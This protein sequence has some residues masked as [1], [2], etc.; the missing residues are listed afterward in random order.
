MTNT[1]QKKIEDK[2][3]YLEGSN[4][5][6]LGLLNPEVV[7]LNENSRKALSSILDIKIIVDDSIAD[8][9]DIRVYGIF[10]D[11]ANP[12]NTLVIKDYTTGTTN[13]VI[14]KRTNGVNSGIVRLTGSSTNGNIEANA[15]IDLDKIP[16]GFYWYQDNTTKSAKFSFTKKSN[17]SATLDNLATEKVTLQN[18]DESLNLRIKAIEEQAKQY[19]LKS[20]GVAEAQNGYY[21]RYTG[22]FTANNNYISRKFPVTNGEVYYAGSRVSG[23]AVALAVYFNGSTFLGYQ[24]AGNNSGGYIQK[25]RERLI[26]PLGTTHIG[27][28]SNGSSTYYG[29]L[30]KLVVDLHGKTTKK[31]LWLGTSIPEQGNSTGDSYPHLVADKLGMT[32]YNESLGSSMVRAANYLG[33]IKGM[34]YEPVLRS[35]SMTIA[36]KQAILDNWT[37]GLNSDGVVTPGGTYGWR[38]LL[39]GTPPANY[40]SYASAET[41]LSWSYENKLVAKYLDTTHEDFVESPD[42]F[43]FDHGHNDLNVWNYDQ[44]GANNGDTNAIAIPNPVNS[45]NRFCGAMNYLIDIILSYNPRAVIVFVGHY[46]ND[47]KTRIY[48]AQQNIA[49]YRNYPLL[50]LWELLGFTQKTITT[51]GYW[52]NSTTWNNSGGAPTSRTMTSIWMYDDLH[53]ATMAARQHIASKLIGFFKAL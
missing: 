25:T 20:D 44:D 29:I 50:K 4:L 34:Y 30:E 47:R 37:S 8:N 51:T 10:T 15:I 3:D 35:L 43:V 18:Y 5:L 1:E 26:L 48:Q 36:E 24:S 52:S 42:I 28:T 27:I 12:E 31:I 38:D 49:A 23:D 46:E 11:A 14:L 17:V 9:A 6:K 53:P 19:E 41:I 40:T 2:F 16:Y 7:L 39:L 32:L 21:S 22:A 13:V 33:T 45:R